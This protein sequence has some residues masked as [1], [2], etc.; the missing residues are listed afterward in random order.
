MTIKSF[1]KP[2]LLALCLLPLSSCSSLFK[3]KTM[4]I[5]YDEEVKLHNG[6]MIWVHITRHY[7]YTS[8]P[9]TGGAYMPSKV[10]ISWDT[11]FEGVGRKSVYFK[12]QITTIEKLNNEWY[13]YGAT[14]RN[15]KG[16]YNQSI[17]CNDVGKFY[18]NGDA[19]LV[20]VN[21][22]GKFL[23][24]P[25]DEI[26]K[27]KTMNI[28]YSNGFTEDETLDKQLIT[29]QKKLDMQYGKSKKDQTINLKLF[30]EQGK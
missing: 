15:V 20:R 23:K 9:S 25:D 11:G 30:S 5:E 21:S 27:L 26:Y 19:C 1:L 17:S 12:R 10:E 6:E 28:L 13:V 18:F 16:S 3:P 22:S 4:T 29:W 8:E 14:D 2:V 24:S 7:F